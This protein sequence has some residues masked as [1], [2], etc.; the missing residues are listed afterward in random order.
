[1]AKLGVEALALLPEAIATI[2]ALADQQAMPD[3]SYEGVLQKLR[4][5]LARAEK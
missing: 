4:S 5:L 3:P 1:M 2:E